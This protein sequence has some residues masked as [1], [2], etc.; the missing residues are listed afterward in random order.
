M[1]SIKNQAASIDITLVKHVDSLKT[2]TLHHLRELEKKMLRAE[3]ENFRISNGRYTPPG[4][5]FFRK[6]V[7][8]TA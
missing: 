2:S 4:K 3:K 6:M 5:S 7:A 8:G 1:N